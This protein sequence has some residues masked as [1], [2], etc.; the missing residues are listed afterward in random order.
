MKGKWERNCGISYMA[1]HWEALSTDPM[2]L[3]SWIPLRL[4]SIK[5]FYRWYLTPQKLHAMNKQ[6]SG[7]CWKGCAQLATDIH[8]W[9]HCAPVQKFWTLIHKELR[10]IY[11]IDMPYSPEAF[12]LNDWECPE[13]DMMKI[14]ATILL[15][16]AK[17]E[18]AAKWKT[19]AE[20]SIKQWQDRLWKCYV[21]AKTTNRVLKMSCKGY[22]SKL[23]DVWAPILDY[24]EEENFVADQ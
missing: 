15:T 23:E 2:M 1:E 11:K 7:Q 4:Q 3:S 20:P 17:M 10:R 24:L 21:M 9:W 13:Q 19:E 18:I 22:R 8:C 16:L 14:S 5:V 12:L 6:V